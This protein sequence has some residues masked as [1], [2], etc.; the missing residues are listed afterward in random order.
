MNTIMSNRQVTDAFG[1]TT[2]KALKAREGV[3]I[4]YVNWLPGAD[5]TMA[6]GERGYMLSDGRMRTFIEVLRLAGRSAL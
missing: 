4:A 5:G 2:L 3:T 1:R 6:N